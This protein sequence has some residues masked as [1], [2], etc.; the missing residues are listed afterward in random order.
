MTRP[1]AIAFDLAAGDR[2]RECLV[3]ARVDLGACT[4]RLGLAL[5][6]EL[7]GQLIAEGERIADLCPAG[8]EGDLYCQLVLAAIRA[9]REEEVRRAH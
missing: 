4:I 9:E 3:T 6:P 2:F 5:C 8:H 1:I 7:G